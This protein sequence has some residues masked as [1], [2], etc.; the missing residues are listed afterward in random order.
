MKINLNYAFQN[1]GDEL[2]IKLDDDDKSIFLN[3]TGTLLFN[4]VK[5]NYGIK[6]EE[7]IN[8]LKEEYEILDKD[9]EEILDF[10]DYL[11]EEKI[12]INEY[13]M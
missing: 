10:I 1:I 7:V 3:E 2:V 11:I 8:M 4:L 9:V 5:E 12:I 13:A 6:K